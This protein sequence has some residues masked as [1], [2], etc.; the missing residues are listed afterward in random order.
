MVIIVF[1][2]KINDLATLFCKKTIH[3]VI[4]KQLTLNEKQVG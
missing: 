3:I 1:T 2:C 4:E